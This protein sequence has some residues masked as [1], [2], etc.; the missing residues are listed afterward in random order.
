MYDDT[1]H[2]CEVSFALMQSVI[3]AKDTLKLP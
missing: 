3:N 2:Q 1:L